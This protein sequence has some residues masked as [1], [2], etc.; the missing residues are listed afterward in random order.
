MLIRTMLIVKCFFRR[1]CE[2]IKAY[3]PFLLIGILPLLLLCIAQ[4]F[5][6]I[7]EP[8]KP[9]VCINLIPSQVLTYVNDPYV[10]LEADVAVY[11]EVNR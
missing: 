10:K 2:T 11:L 8:K 4:P 6:S 5:P 3:L 7:P 9:S 1:I